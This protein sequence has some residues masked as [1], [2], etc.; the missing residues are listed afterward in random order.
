[1]APTTCPV[2]DEQFNASGSTRDHAWAAHQACHYCGEQ[3]DNKET[4]Y[5]HWLAVHSEELSRSDHKRAE[6]AVGPLTFTDRLAQQGAAAAVG[7]LRRRTFLLGGGTAAIGGAAIVGVVFDRMG[8]KNGNETRT[9]TT[10]SKTGS[11]SAAPIPSSVNNHDYAV[12][13]TGDADVTVTYFGSWKCPYCGQFSAEFLPTL[14]SDYVESGEIT[15]EFRN[16]TYIDGDPFLGPDAPAAGQAGLAIW[17]EYP[18][19][20]WAYHEYLFRNQ[21]PENKRWA[22]ADNLVSF[23]QKAGVPDPSVIRT[24]IQDGKYEDQLRA[25]SQ[26]AAAAGIDGTPTLLVEGTPVSPFEKERTRRLI[27]DEIS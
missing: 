11:V 10:T 23:A 15:L 20:Y 25:T 2:C 8:D 9:G 13:A 19:S 5:T 26:A 12:A 14:I 24:A 7:G 27:E 4:L 17:N 18:E 3:V 6:S 22:T 16:L 1:M 21:P